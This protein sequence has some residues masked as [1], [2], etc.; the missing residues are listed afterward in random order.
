M[1]THR[2]N[3][4]ADSRQVVVRTG[5]RLHFGLLDTAAPFGGAGMMI[6]RPATEIRLQPAAEF[7]AVATGPAAQDLRRRIGEVAG[8]FQRCTALDRLPPV[9]VS[10]SRR[11]EA[12]SGLGTGTQLAMAVAAGLNHCLD[13]GLDRE[14]LV[15][16][17]A[18]RGARS[19][20]G[21]HGFFTGG[22]IVDSETIRR[23]AIPAAWRIV[24]LQPR[25]ASERVS[26]GEENRRFARL[27]RAS[28]SQRAA[29]QACLGEQLVPAAQADAFDR[30]APA[31]RRYNWLSGKLFEAAQGGPYHG[32][33][34][35]DLVHAVQQ[36]GYEAVGQSSWG[37]TVFVV[38]PS[39]DQAQRLAADPPAPAAAARIVAPLNGPAS[40]G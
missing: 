39:L 33:A 30:F 21:S 14:A 38:C 31:L 7:E 11:P 3:W 34:I 5:A 18:A 10:V 4:K 24:L 20:V 27:P 17:V 2:E 22:L 25:Q 35:A 36:A 26:G 40:I 8:R 6:D 12:H 15:R 9:R 28:E 32:G 1:Q 16:H 37:P 23:V 29:L 13:A 19:G